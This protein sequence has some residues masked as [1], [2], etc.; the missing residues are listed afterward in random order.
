MPNDTWNNTTMKSIIALVALASGL[1]GWAAF[2]QSSLNFV[3]L[4][5]VQFNTNG[6]SFQINAVAGSSTM[7]QFTFT[8]TDA[9]LNG[10]ITGA[11]WGVNLAGLATATGGSLTNE[12]A[13]MASG[14]QL[15]ISDGTN[16]LTGNLTWL[17]IHLLSNGQ[18]GV[19]D[20]M[21]VNLTG[22]A[23]AGDN[24]DLLALVAGGNGNLN[25]TF[26]FSGVNP[27]LGDLFAGNAGTASTSFS[28]AVSSVAAVPEPATTALFMVSVGLLAVSRWRTR[29]GVPVGI[30]V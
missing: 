27:T 14:G 22:L 2:G 17:Q 23:Y 8:G 10:W 30:N 1:T 26:Q 16:T 24:A 13:P 25:L 9:G 19:G 11:P 21:S 29:P 20:S 15:N 4:N 7:P 6:D 5:E 3:G 28:G 12:Q 18:G